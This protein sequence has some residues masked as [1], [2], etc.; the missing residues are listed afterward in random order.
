MQID[1]APAE[2]TEVKI[3]RINRGVYVNGE[4][5]LPYGIL[6]RN[7][8]PTQLAYYKKCG[9]DYIEFISHW[10]QM[11]KN[12]KFLKDCEKLKIKAVAFHVARPYAASPSEAAK[13]YKSSP[14]LVG[15][16]PNDESG[17]LIVYER[18][19]NTQNGLS[20]NLKLP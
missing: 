6:V 10:N 8:N 18:A 12:L 9:F 5:F 19:I 3:N 14:A 1:K 11:Q 13:I 4:P 20:A 15:I 17:D 7:L 16:V 2:Q